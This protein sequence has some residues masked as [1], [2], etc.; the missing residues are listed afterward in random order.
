MNFLRILLEE[1]VDALL[2]AAG[3]EGDGG[4]RLGF[5]AL[6]QGRA[7]H[8]RQRSTWQEMGR[9]FYCRGRRPAC[10][11]G[12]RRGRTRCSKAAQAASKA[13]GVIALR[14]RGPG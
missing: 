9:R 11:R 2:V 13:W 5:A 8:A 12:S 4:Q 3:A 7:V 1:A 14:P 6:E 10:R